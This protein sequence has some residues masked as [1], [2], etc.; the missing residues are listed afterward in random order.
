MN[1][2]SDAHPRCE[3]PKP[4][5]LQ[6][7][8][9]VRQRSVQIIETLSAEDCCAQS[10][11]EASPTKWHLAHSSW[12]FETFV[13]EPHE[14]GFG[15]H[16]PAY[17]VLFN[18]YYRGVGDQHPR[19][20]RGLLTRPSLAE[21]LD[22]RLAVDARVQALLGER[23]EDPVLHE[24]VTLGLQH[25][26]QHQELMLS[27]L[28]HLLAQNPMLPAYLPR[29]EQPERLECG[30][31]SSLVWLSFEQ[32]MVDIGHSGSDFCFDNELPRHR[33]YLQAFQLASR[34]VTNAEVL[35]F[36]AEGGYQRP[37]LW[38]AEGWDWVQAQ[39]L[40]HPLYWSGGAQTGW[41][42]FTLFGQQALELQ[43]PALHLSLFEA[44]AYARWAGARLPT[45]FEWEFALQQRPAALTQMFGEA[46][47]WTSSAYA[48]YPGFAA[49]PG[50]V[51][52][53]NGKFMVNQYVLRGSSFA[54]P[55]GHER[56]SY[57]NFF[58]AATRW[59]F[60]GLRLAK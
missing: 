27:D 26:Q 31:T 57:R 50:A 44:D 14:A 45:E 16:H 19:P 59:Q 53:Y 5:L 33:R 46:W 23:G 28:K 9:Q 37:E 35:A 36:I 17:R 40:Q 32:G 56:A 38:L 13:L 30:P 51:G 2:S 43:A 55:S 47:Q 54:T 52:E 8:R 12:F 49:A 21:V 58:P 11:P 7:F 4:S 1:S 34:L 18:S 42:Q 48:P 3:G 6:K 41:C 20:R 24:L 29:P 22:Y 25:E 39:G 15:A 60:S 10:M